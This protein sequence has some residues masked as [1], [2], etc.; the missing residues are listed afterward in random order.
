MATLRPS[1][2]A[3]QAQAPLP[4]SNNGLMKL[5][6]EAIEFRFQNTLITPPEQWTPLAEVQARHLLNR[7]RLQ[8]LLPNLTMLRGQIAAEREITE[9]KPEQSPL[10]AGF[11]DLPQKM[12]D[13]HRRK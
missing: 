10:H 4:G 3:E 2:T 1:P 12:L 5:D 8:M 9:P 13:G 6:D 11:I 7:A